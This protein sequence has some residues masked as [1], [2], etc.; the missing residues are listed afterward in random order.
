[1]IAAALFDLDGVIV[2]TEPS[3]TLFWRQAGRDFGIPGDDFADIIKGQTLTHILST[4]FPE[5]DRAREV[6][7]ALADFEA[8]MDFPLVP[9][10]LDFICRL[11]AM[12][13]PAAVVTSSDQTKMKSLYRAR[14]DFIG[15]FDVILTA[16]DAQRSKPHPD[17]Y[18]TAAHRLGSDIGRCVVFEDSINGLKA[19]R[20]AG[21]TVVGLSTS[22]P[23]AVI[24]PLS[25]HVIADFT[26]TDE[27]ALLRGI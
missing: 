20:A 5:P 27:V 15:Y 9:G 10:A 2:D 22:L 1:M 19:G 13:I 26:H 6:V 12:G 23:K 8:T 17:C 16:E 14:P 11:R 21:A 18:L 7:Q 3:Y 25:D 24:E 4:Y